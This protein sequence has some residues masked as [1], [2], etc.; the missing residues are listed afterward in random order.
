M[1]AGDEDLRYEWGRLN[2]VKEVTNTMA[3]RKPPEEIW[4]HYWE[5]VYNQAER[6]LGWVL[7][8]VGAAV[9]ASYGIWQFVAALFADTASPPFIRYAVFSLLV[10]GV[11]LLFSVIREKLFTRGNDPYKEVQR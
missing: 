2:R 5:S 10:G 1:L 7:I 11:I 4:H 6:G 8:S 3:Y 9:L